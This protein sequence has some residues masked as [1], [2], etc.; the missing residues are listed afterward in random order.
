MFVASPYSVTT[1]ETCESSETPVAFTARSRSLWI[2]F[3]TDS[4]N[5]AKGF[6]IPYVTYNGKQGFINLREDKNCL[7]HFQS[8]LHLFFN[9][10]QR[11][12]WKYFFYTRT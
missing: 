3:K 5:N 6:S 10:K 7:I 1:F 2:Y 12:G 11:L 8:I 9:I 4:E